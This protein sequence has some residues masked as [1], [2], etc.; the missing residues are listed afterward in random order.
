M[1]DYIFGIGSFA[2]DREF[3]LF[4]SIY[5][6]N[7][8]VAV[9]G[10]SCCYYLSIEQIWSRTV[11]TMWANRRKYTCTH[12][13][14]YQRASLINYRLFFPIFRLFDQ[15]RLGRFHYFAHFRFASNC[16]HTFAENI[17]CTLYRLEY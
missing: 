4:A 16:I 7:F 14:L 11:W 3:F 9:V 5:S 2:S 10:C 12:I 15:S 8:V 17:L 6:F 13:R 1:I